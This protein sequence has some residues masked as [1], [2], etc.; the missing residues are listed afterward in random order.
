MSGKDY[1]Y[2]VG[3]TPTYAPNNYGAT[4]VPGDLS[5]ACDSK[6]TMS[7]GMA[8]AK[9]T[10]AGLPVEYANGSS[11]SPVNMH[12]RADGAGALK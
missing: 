8:C 5:V 2:S 12:P 10:S 7:K 3:P 1:C 11:S 9:L 6:V 4:Y